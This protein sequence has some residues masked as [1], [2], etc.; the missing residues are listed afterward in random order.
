MLWV[1]FELPARLYDVHRHYM[2]HLLNLVHSQPSAEAEFYSFQTFT[3]KRAAQQGYPE[4]VNTS[5]AKAALFGF[6]RCHL[7]TSTV[8]ETR[9]GVPS[10][11][12][13]AYHLI[14]MHLDG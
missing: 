12:E 11:Q 3:V 14:R 10:F 13:E 8:R 7:T 1:W 2:Q 5:P 9:Y 4:A 6:K